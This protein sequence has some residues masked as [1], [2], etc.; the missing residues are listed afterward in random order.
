MKDIDCLDTESTHWLVQVKDF[1]AGAGTLTASAVAEVI[2]HAASASRPPVRIVAI[3]DGQLGGQLAESGWNRAVSETPSYGAQSTIAA[4]TRLGYSSAYA[5]ALLMRTHVVTY[6]WNIGPLL[7]NSI[8]ATYGVKPA[9]AALIAGRLVDSLGKIAA[10][11]RSVTLSTT[12]RFRR[13]DLD[14][15][16]RKTLTV[17]DVNALDSAVRLGVCDIADY[18]GHPP[19]DQSRFL[20]GVD[21]IPAHIGA[22]FDVLRPTP[23]RAVQRAIEAARYALVAG[24]SGAGKSTQVWRSA[25][26]VATAVRVVRVHRVQSDG[27]VAELVRHVELL[28]VRHVIICG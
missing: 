26:D 9:V 16:V 12:G 19:S 7:T 11:Q 20:Q 21:A 22:G 28:V 1:G 5:N 8:A 13:A 6:P 27:D 18:T 15:L 25:R 10:D 14:V 2:A 3:T 4:L 23:C 17:V 24:P